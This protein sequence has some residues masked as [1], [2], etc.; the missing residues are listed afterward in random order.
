MVKVKAKQEFEFVTDVT[1]W[2][3]RKNGEEFVVS[4]ERAKTLLDAGLVTLVETVTEE[5]TVPIEPKKRGRKK[6]GGKN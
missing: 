5:E 3:S 1:V 2:R 4:E 6:N